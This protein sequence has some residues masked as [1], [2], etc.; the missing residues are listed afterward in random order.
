MREEG[1]KGGIKGEERGERRR[2]EEG[3]GGVD[4]EEGKGRGKW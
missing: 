3:R 2:G 1:E 4:G